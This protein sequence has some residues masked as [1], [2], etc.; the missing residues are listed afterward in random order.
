MS[1]RHA[2][3][4]PVVAA[5][6]ARDTMLSHLLPVSSRDLRGTLLA[7][8]LVLSCSFYTDC[9]CANQPASKTGGTA[10][11]GPS[12]GSG[13]TSAGS[14]NT[15][16]GGTEMPGG[17]GGETGGEVVQPGAWR[18]ATGNLAG[19]SVACGNVNF[20]SVKPDENLVI[21]SVAEDG[22]YGSRD[23]G[24][25]W[26]ALGQGPKSVLIDNLPTAILYDPDDSARFWEVGIYG[27]PGVYRTD[28]NGTTFRVLGN[29][30]HTDLLS[31]DWSDPERRFM[32]LGAHEKAQTLYRTDDG[33][34]NWDDIGADVPDTCEWTSFPI[35]VD[36]D[37]WLLGC[38]SSIYGTSDAGQ[39]WD[40]L[41][42]F[43]GASVPLV[44]S[45]KVIYWAIALSGGMARS[46]DDGKTWERVV[47]GGGIVSSI[48]PIELPDGTIATTSGNTIVRSDDNGKSWK[49]ITQ[50]APFSPAGIV[51][52]EAE[53]AFFAWQQGCETQLP[54]TG[55]VRADVTDF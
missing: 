31:I 19:K 6:H 1:V 12:A 54:A 33:G 20:M 47:G 29:V 13:G 39:T 11:K 38:G 21:A 37:N 44:T 50:A 5:R 32:L 9:P 18:P 51:Y 34:Q 30:T 15:G 4:L 10:G 49:P 41:S 22:L 28:D 36:Q 27:G 25:T 2:N 46:D 23:G 26:K 45:Q 8:A 24:E 40:V 3:L 16:V 7:G 48:H 53:G 17:S 43:G 42:S 14:G 55:I 52:S 35:I